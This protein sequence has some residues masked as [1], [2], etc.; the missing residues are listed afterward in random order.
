MQKPLENPSK[1]EDLL[2]NLTSYVC[3][4]CYAIFSNKEKALKHAVACGIEFNH[5][6]AETG[7]EKC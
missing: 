2:I 1:E 7:D 5:V 6:K 4:F 3:K